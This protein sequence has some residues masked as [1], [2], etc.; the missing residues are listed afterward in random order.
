MEK[1]V[2]VLVPVVCKAK[3]NEA[4]GVKGILLSE[5]YILW[6]DVSVEH[7]EGVYVCNS[8]EEGFDESLGHFFGQSAYIE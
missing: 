1:V 3:V 2:C 8:R 5:D 4:D 7:S 6:F